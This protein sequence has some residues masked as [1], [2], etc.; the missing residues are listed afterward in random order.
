MSTGSSPAKSVQLVRGLFRTVT[1]Y[2]AGVRGLDAVEFVKQAF[3]AVETFRAQGG[4]GGYHCE[5]RLGDAGLMMGGGGAYQG[6]DHPCAIQLIVPD[7]DAAYESAMRA[8]GTSVYPPT[9]QP[10]GDRD[11]GVKDMMGN[12]WYLAT[13]RISAHS[14][15]DMPTVT[16]GFSMNNPEMFIEFL[17]AAFGATE[18]FRHDTP[19]GKIVHARL[20]VGSSMLMVGRARGEF[21]DLPSM[22]Y[23]YVDDSEAVYARAVEVGATSIFPVSENYGDRIGAVTDPFG[24]QWFIAT[25]V[26][27]M[28]P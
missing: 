16:P 22:F 18:A 28:R 15:A 14:P 24:H 2:L 6:P 7:A 23:V 3:G 9:D 26:K 25:N 12:L 19:D 1:P 13:R 17:K 11:A 21:Q 8:G 10:W 5:L 4:A 20:W 27:P